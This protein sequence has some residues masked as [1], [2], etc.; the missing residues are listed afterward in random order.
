MI[1]KKGKSRRKRRF[2]RNLS[3][4]AHPLGGALRSGDFI[5]A[6]VKKSGIDADESIH[7]SFH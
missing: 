1:Y 5:D 6:R 3:L 7:L 4:L 2:G